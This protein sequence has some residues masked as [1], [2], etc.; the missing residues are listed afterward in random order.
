VWGFHGGHGGLKLEGHAPASPDPSSSRSGN[1]VRGTIRLGRDIWGG[2]VCSAWETQTWRLFSDLVYEPKITT[3]N[4]GY[5]GDG[6]PQA[7]IIL[8]TKI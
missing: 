1:W 5:H 2:L 7:R 4:P 8:A 3:Y 6:D